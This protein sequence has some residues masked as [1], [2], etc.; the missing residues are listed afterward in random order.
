V[1]ILCPKNTP[2]AQA[3]EKSEGHLES[4]AIW[5]QRP[6]VKTIKVGHIFLK[7]G[8]GQ[9]GYFL[10]SVKKRLGTGWAQKWAQTDSVP[11]SHKLEAKKNPGLRPRFFIFGCGNRTRTYDLRVMSPTSCQLLHPASVLAFSPIG[12]NKNSSFWAQ[13][14]TEVTTD[15]RRVFGLCIWL[16]EQDSNL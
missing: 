6:K 16:R 13:I 8:E 3:P 10:P 5:A 15:F 9:N 11:K 7:T 1:P 4:P 14:V 12:L 2:W